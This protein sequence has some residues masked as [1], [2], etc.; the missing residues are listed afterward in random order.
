VPRPPRKACLAI[1]HKSWSGP[2]H[3]LVRLCDDLP[4][5]I[6]QLP[7]IASDAYSRQ[8]TEKAL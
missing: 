1:G 8:L 5:L 3:V 4:Y 7:H 6:K 2:G